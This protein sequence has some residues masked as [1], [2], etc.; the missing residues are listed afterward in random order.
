MKTVPVNRAAV[1]PS[2]RVTSARYVPSVRPRDTSLTLATSRSPTRLAAVSTR[3]VS[4]ATAASP[5]LFEARE[6]AQSAR[7]KTIPP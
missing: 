2:P 7:E 1:R 3:W 4:M 5:A 6:K